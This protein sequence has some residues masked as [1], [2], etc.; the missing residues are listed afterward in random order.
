MFKKG[1]IF[2]RIGEVGKW[3]PK[4]AAPYFAPPR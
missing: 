4:A 2:L 3:R 1:N